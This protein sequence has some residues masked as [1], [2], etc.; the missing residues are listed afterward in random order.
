MWKNRLAGI[1]LLV[2][3]LTPLTFRADI[4]AEQGSGF[5]GTSQLSAS[6]AHSI[7]VRADG[8]VY[9]T[10]LL[11]DGDWVIVNKAFKAFSK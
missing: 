5:S 11:V 3:C 6:A 1:A 2:A 10:L 7:A 9:L 4:F 8:T